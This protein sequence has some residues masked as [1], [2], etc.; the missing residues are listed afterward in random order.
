MA[1]TVSPKQRREMATPQHPEFSDM[2]K[3]KRGSEAP[4][5]TAVLPRRE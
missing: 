1:S 3:A 2:T 4:A 5:Q